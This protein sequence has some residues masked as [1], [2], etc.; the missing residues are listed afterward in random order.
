MKPSFL[1]CVV[2][3]FISSCLLG[4]ASHAQTVPTKSSTLEGIVANQSTGAPV[5]FA[6]VRLA[7]QDDQTVSVSTVTDAIGHFQFNNLAQGSYSLT[8]D[9]PDFLP[10]LP[11]TASV[12]ADPVDS[13]LQLAPLGVIAGTVF[14]DDGDPLSG[15]VVAALRVTMK[16][17]TTSLSHIAQ[18][19]TND[20]GTYRLH[21]LPPGQYYVKVNQ[22]D[23]T[24]HTTNDSQGPAVRTLFY[25]PS[26]SQDAANG[27]EIAAGSMIT[28][29]NLEFPKKAAT[30][31]SDTQSL[32]AAES[33]TI[34]GQVLNSATGDAVSNAQIELLGGDTSQEPSTRSDTSGHFSFSGV[35][36]GTYRISAVHNGFLA[37]A[38]WSLGS[39]GSEH[40]ITTAAGQTLDTVDLRLVPQG[41]IAGRVL[42]GS[43]PLS[44][45]I[46]MAVRSSFVAGRRKLI[47]ASRTYTNDLGEYRL[48]DL[49][50]GHYYL[51]VTYRD[52]TA[53]GSPR[54]ADANTIQSSPP[55]ED[56]VNTFYPEALTLADATPLEITPGSIQSSI[57]VALFRMHKWTVSGRVLFPSGTRFTN[58]PMAV[59]LPRDPTLIVKFSQRT[60][61]VDAHTGAFAIDGVPPGS[62]TLAVDTQIGDAQYAASQL[63]NLTKADVSGLAVGLTRSFPVRGHV[64]AEGSDQCLFSGLGISAQSTGEQGAPH[65]ARAA[66]NDSGLFILENLRPDHYSLK[67]SGLTGNCYVRSVSVGTSDVTSTD[68]QLAQGS[69]PIEFVLSA[70]GGKIDGDLI[71]D[72]HQPVKSATVVLIPQPPLRDRE[73]LYK[74]IATDQSGNFS[75]QG[76]SPGNYKLF[77]WNAIEPDSYLDPEVLAPF[78]GLGQDVSIQEAGQ[79]KIELTVIPND[80]RSTP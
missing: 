15:A 36:P 14:A 50:P 27:L 23:S 67:L 80:G 11:V 9:R 13:K 32:S 30:T 54:F 62:Y 63:V 42:E 16:D 49:Q 8:A 45:A 10:S 29:I 33:A 5:P 46:V 52:G 18:T 72:Q 7:K 6:D 17:G 60:A 56:F 31:G 34:Q 71:D 2:A 53:P 19:T 22:R 12:G 68:V 66:V 65:N 57:D 38:P 70:N 37:H 47:L 40:N 20:L 39:T 78:E 3:S 51:S 58:P 28:G 59:L 48:F 61:S 55:Q 43:V 73:D 21:G 41:V 35:P 79:S 25:P 75:L 69:S 77:A 64:V 4:V 76:I 1:P 44:N 26:A 74:K 24:A